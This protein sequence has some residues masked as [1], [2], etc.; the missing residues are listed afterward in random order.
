MSHLNQALAY[1]QSNHDRYLSE[2]NEYIRIPSISTLAE[3]KPDMQR[4]AEW[5]SA[6]M[7]GMGLSNVSIYPTAGHPVVYGEWLGAP[8]KP[9]L[10]IYGHYD[11]Q[12]VDPLSEWNSPP[13]EPTVRGDNLYAR[14]AADMKSQMHSCLKALE[15]YLRAGALPVNVKLLVEGEE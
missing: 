7:K 15:A 8:G 2:L 10:L 14:G 13:F 1:A 4:A 9:T 11:V 5:L 6:Q 12:P 3:H